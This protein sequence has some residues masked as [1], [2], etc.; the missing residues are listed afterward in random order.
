MSDTDPAPPT[1]TDA[2]LKEVIEAINALRPQRSRRD[3][4]WRAIAWVL[5]ICLTA[6]ITNAA[7]PGAHRVFAAADCYQKYLLHSRTAQPA[8]TEWKSFGVTSVEAVSST[9]V[10]IT[11]SVFGY[12]WFGATLPFGRYCD[13]RLSF[14]AV[15]SRPTI[16]ER[17]VGYGY[18]VGVR[19][20]TINGVPNAITTQYDPPF[21]GLRILPIPCCANQ[22]GYNAVNLPRIVSG[23]SHTWLLT[24]IGSTAY[25]AFDHKGFGTMTDLGGGNEVLIRAWNA[26]VTISDVKI[27]AIRPAL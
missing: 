8:T 9:A 11:P 12:Q 15:L 22:E 16:S 13:Y 6:V 25:I 27:S 26:S 18:A 24:V 21:A 20:T 7:V 10:T 2:S 3:R 23:V 5:V 4:I 1:I 17:G 19:G 14:S